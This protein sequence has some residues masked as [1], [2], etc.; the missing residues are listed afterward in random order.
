MLTLGYYGDS[1]MNSG[2][3]QR[4]NGVAA[5]RQIETILRGEISAGNLT[6]GQKLPTEPQLAERFGVNRHTVRRALLVMAQAGLLSIEQGR[7]T[8]VRDQ[9]IEYPI[10]T[11]TRF[12]EIIAAQSHEPS[13]E[14]VASEILSA[15]KEIAEPLMIETAAVV[16]RLD[17]LNLADGVPICLASNWF[18]ARRFPD[19]IEAY[20]STGSISGAFARYGLENYRRLRTSLIAR[21]PSRKDADVLRQPP[22]RPIL[23]AES[24]N[25]DEDGRPVQFSQSRFAGDRVQIR[26]EP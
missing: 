8:F 18:P 1:L 20:R 17:V 26:L 2:E 6:S 11:R 14:M 22:N 21:I 5:W 19:I 4:G 12:S 7:G 25:G 24:V 10:G 3:I 9:V 23:V 13:G 15:S 16:I